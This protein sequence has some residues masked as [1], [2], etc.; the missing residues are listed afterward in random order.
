MS[1]SQSSCNIKLENR[2]G[3]TF[4]SREAE[5]ESGN[6]RYTEIELDER[7]GNHEGFFELGSNFTQTARNV[8]L[9]SDGHVPYLKAELQMGSGN[10]RDRIESIN[11]DE[12]IGND[13][14]VNNRFALL[15]SHASVLDELNEG[16]LQLLVPL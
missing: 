10:Y 5:S 16:L 14:G 11:L 15:H 2:D 3:K 4:L 6:V 9:E 13:N 7:I 1:F 12:Y 8:Y